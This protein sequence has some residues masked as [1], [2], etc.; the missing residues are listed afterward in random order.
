MSNALGIALSAFRALFTKLDVTANNLA[1]AGTAGFKKSRADFQEAPPGGVK[2]SISTV[3]TPGSPLPPAEGEREYQE[4]SNVSLAE[5]MVNLIITQYT[6][7]ANLKT[8]QAGEEM[9]KN[10]LDIKV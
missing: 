1:N 2:V 3:D 6:F 5:E 10:L 8:L 9:Q 7:S 4:S